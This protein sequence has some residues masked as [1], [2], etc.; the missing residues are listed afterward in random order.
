MNRILIDTNVILYTYDYRDQLRKNRAAEVLL[1]LEKYKLGI[2]TIQTLS[3]F[4][5][6][7]TKVRNPIIEKSDFQLQLH[8]WI[9]LFPIIQLTQNIVVEATRCVIDHNFSYYDAQI[10]AAAKL[11]QIPVIFSEDFQ[12]GQTLEG[13][14]FVNPFSEK[15]DINQW[16]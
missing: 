3:E 7:V 15:F 11:N 2:F 10:W 12:D 4:M 6:V 13:V 14:H 8:Y 1:V 16:C 9:N 5:N